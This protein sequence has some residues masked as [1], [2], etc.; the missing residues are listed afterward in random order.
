ML[1]A[2]KEVATHMFNKSGGKDKVFVY[3]IHDAPDP[4]KI[5]EL[6]IFIRAIGYD[7]DTNGGKV[8]ARD[9][10]KLFDQIKGKPEEDLIK[11]A[12]IRSMAKAVYSTKNIGH[13]GLSFKH[14]THFTSPI[15]RYPD[16][17]VHRIM[18]SHL[19]GEKVSAKEVA[20]YN[21]LSI[22][23]SEREIEAIKAERD[24]IKYKQVEYMLDKIGEEFNSI[25][26][27]VTEWGVYVEE[28][29]TRAEGLVRIST[30]EDDYYTLDAQKYRV[31]GERS[32]KELSLGD[33]CKVKLI[34][35]DLDMKTLDFEII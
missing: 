20:D 18:K 16:M 17:M 22:K 9:I 34:A 8:K 14:Y 4:E 29:Q 3:R 15:R 28:T 10:N 11:V 5:E 31:I 27:G 25:I 13:F 2:N 21:Y 26:T 7:F 12:T 35:A 32:K 24:S 33:T 23:S 30:L 19:K 1:L 6:G